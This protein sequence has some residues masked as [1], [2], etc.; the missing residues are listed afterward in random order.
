MN[1]QNDNFTY[2]QKYNNDDDA[3]AI[4]VLDGGEMKG[5][6]RV[7]IIESYGNEE[8]EGEDENV[9]D[10]DY[11]EEQEKDENEENLMLSDSNRLSA[12]TSSSTN[13]DDNEKGYEKENDVSN[14][15]ED[16]EDDEILE[17]ANDNQNQEQQ[18]QND[19]L[20]LSPYLAQTTKEYI[21]ASKR[22][23][24]N[25]IQQLEQM[26]PIPFYIYDHPNITLVDIKLNMVDRMLHRIGSESLF[27]MATIHTL[28]MSSWKTNDPDKARL[29]IIP[30]PIGRISCSRQHNYF[31]V[32]FSTLLKEPLFQST[33]GHD[34]VLPGSPFLLFRGDKKGQHGKMTTWMPHLWN[35][36]VASSYDQNAVVNA[37]RDGTNFDEYTPSFAKLN[38]LNKRTFSIGLTGGT[39][40]PLRDIHSPHQLEP[41][42][43]PLTLATTEKFYNSSNFI[44][45]HTPA[46]FTC[47]HNSTIHR[48]APVTN[49]T[50]ESFPKSSI[51]HGVKPWDLWIDTYKDSKFCL[52]IRG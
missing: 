28:N 50:F 2:N 29:F 46:N 26:E 37:I 6:G 43:F 25:K 31:D 15:E 13:Q 7:K 3:I 9:K 44:F 17:E 4:A 1:Q 5:A 18:L 34:H 19:S 14:E 22:K 21:Q 42:E 36:T 20:S 41:Y 11:D 33:Y 16:E 49:I 30:T 27:D 48:M 24:E 51:G 8:K 23:L 40:F 12:S 38:A 32:A 10:D 39:N 52:C 47:F 35:V 45:Y